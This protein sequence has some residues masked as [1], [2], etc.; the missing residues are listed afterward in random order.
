MSLIHELMK[1]KLSTEERAESSVEPVENV[2][3]ALDNVE[4]DLDAVRDEV[5]SIKEDTSDIAEADGTG[6][7]LE[8]TIQTMEAMLSDDYVNHTELRLVMARG[9]NLL[10]RVGVTPSELSFEA[11]A[12]FDS[13]ESRHETLTLA[14]EG[15][16]ERAGQLKEAISASAQRIWA[17][18]K[19]VFKSLTDA[20]HRLASLLVTLEGQLAAGGAPVADTVA[21]SKR[22]H[23][24][25]ADGK[26]FLIP[27][28]GM[29]TKLISAVKY[30]FDTYLPAVMRATSGDAIKPIDAKRFEG[31]GGGLTVGTSNR[32]NAPV[33]ATHRVVD[34]KRAAATPAAQPAEL[35]KILQN[36]KTLSSTDLKLDYEETSTAAAVISS[37][38]VDLLVY[39][40]RIMKAAL[41]YVKAQLS[42]YG[43]KA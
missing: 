37:A 41:A 36:V 6:E 31:L 29:T 10:G 15:F 11:H 4:S 39:K 14:T 32:F 8:E 35:K 17:R 33:F 26:G 2:D 22:D 21:M 12:R 9:R 13:V 40:F 28:G 38:M 43:A 34:P 42:N 3:G 1:Q 20:D 25:L 19:E 16:R 23:A 27:V 5:E 7:K 24:W 30:S 18:I